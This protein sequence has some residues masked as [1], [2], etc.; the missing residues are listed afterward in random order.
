MKPRRGETAFQIQSNGP[1]LTPPPDADKGCGVLGCIVP[2]VLLFTLCTVFDTSG[3]SSSSSSDLSSSFSSPV[4]PTPPRPSYAEFRVEQTSSETVSTS[5]T[6][7]NEKVQVIR[8]A[9][10][11]EVPRAVRDRAVVLEAGGGNVAVMAGKL[12]YILVG[13]VAVTVGSLRGRDRWSADITANR[14]NV[15]QLDSWVRLQEGLG[16]LQSQ[17]SPF[18]SPEGRLRL[19][20]MRLAVEGARPPPG[21]E[22][23]I[24]VTPL[25]ALE[26][27]TR[28]EQMRL[29]VEGAR[30]PPDGEMT[31]S[32]SLELQDLTSLEQMRFAVEEARSPSIEG[33]R[34]V[35]VVGE[36]S[37]F[38][39]PD[40]SQHSSADVR[41]LDL[42]VT[43]RE[44]ERYKQEVV[45]YSI[46][47]EHWQRAK[48]SSPY[49]KNNK[50]ST[51][52]PRPRAMHR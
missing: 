12:P 27:K 16:T 17:K 24:P 2:A 44:V 33:A 14:G 36:I 43:E 21:G 1:S 15:D 41:V 46:A 19:E 29:A 10:L 22:L 35:Y 18:D 40:L 50:H 48:Q 4:A 37:S 31:P 34:V 39:G 38:K 45:N 25:E 28:L 5:V 23:L 13:T 32:S 9:S 11:Q 47:R 49:G 7:R 8:V 52:K 6:F 30:P 42:R 3:P 26:R 20:Q 51:A